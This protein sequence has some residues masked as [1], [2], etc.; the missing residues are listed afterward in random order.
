[1]LQLVDSNHNRIVTLEAKIKKNKLRAKMRQAETKMLF[2]QLTL[3]E[4]L[5]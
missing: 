5:N 3:L 4:E 2:E 1:L